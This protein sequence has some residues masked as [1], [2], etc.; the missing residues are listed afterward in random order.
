MI[1]HRACATPKK[2]LTTKTAAPIMADAD[3]KDWEI[4]ADKVSSAGWS[5]GRMSFISADGE[6]RFC[7]DAHR[8]DGKR[9]IV[10]SDQLLT[11]FLELEQQTRRGIITREEI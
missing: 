10:H 7:V 3:M 4:I 9:Y 8:D 11:A 6:K 5:H 1:F 2:R